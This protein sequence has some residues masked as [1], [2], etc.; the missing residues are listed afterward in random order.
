VAIE[1]PQAVTAPS[2]LTPGGV[3]P[4]RLTLEEALNK[5]AAIYNLRLIASK[6]AAPKNERF[7]IQLP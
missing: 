4:G 2:H 3:G 1:E 6:S 5:S 7:L